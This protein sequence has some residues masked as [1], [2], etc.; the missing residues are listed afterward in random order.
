MQ[1]AEYCKH[2]N[3]GHVDYLGRC[4]KYAQ[5]KD[6][7]RENTPW[8]KFCEIAHFGWCKDSQRRKLYR[9]VVPRLEY[10][11]KSVS[12]YDKAQP[13]LDRKAWNLA[14]EWTIAHFSPY[15]MGSK[16]V[17]EE[18]VIREC[19]K[20]TSSGYPWNLSFPKKKDFFESGPTH[21]LPAFW[22]ELGQI[23]EMKMMP[24][25]VCAQKRELRL[26]EKLDDG[27]VRTFTAS[28]IEH[29]LSLARLCLD[30]NNKFYA[31]AG[32][33]WS[34]VGS[35][36]FLRG[37]HNLYLRLSKHP[38]AFELDESEY[39][40]SLFREAMF[41][42]RDIRWE[43]MR[44]SDK[45]NPENKRRLWRLYDHIVDSVIVLENGELI[46]KH[47][48]NPSG[49]ANT[50]VD[51]TMILFRLFAYAWII[52]ARR[53]K[54]MNQVAVDAMRDADPELRNYDLP[55]FGEYS[56]FM[57]HVEAALNGDD[58]TFT[59]SDFVREWFNPKTIREIWSGIGITTK[60]P[61]DE[62]RKLEE[63]QFL[64][65]GFVKIGGLW[66][67]CP[68]TDRVLCSLEHASPKDD[69]RWHLMRAHALR[70]SS[71][72]NTEC[73]QII[74]SFIEYLRNDPEWSSKLHGE[75]DGMDMK[76]ID[77]GWKMNRYIWGLYSG[78]ESDGCD[79][80][81]PGDLACARA[82]FDSVSRAA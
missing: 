22:N 5:F 33:H 81:S 32:K 20:S 44:Q 62:P 11:F 31:T 9:M 10:G 26:S 30:F 19:D 41:G 29:A 58:N 57:E 45:E 53:F 8:K 80:V 43:M 71:W 46:M 15:V 52:Q 37:W 63:C 14:G 36:P 24:I 68:D 17:D 4:V 54:V 69:P 38:N 13:Q 42:Q 70:M 59:V 67:P 25:W 56:D 61:C 6:Q 50:I 60:T 66:L 74:Q 23:D 7:S 3:K 82:C 47:T 21:V 76:T 64:S 49:S 65:H 51:N 12:K 34:F 75:I 78:Y 72:A 48:G 40:S 2:F 73:R 79:R 77:R 28:P 18:V 39:D 1:S 35:S 27:K 16:I 55:T